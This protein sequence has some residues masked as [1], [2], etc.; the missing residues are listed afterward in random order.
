MAVPGKTGSQYKDSE[1][2]ILSDSRDDKYGVLATEMVAENPGGTALVRLKTDSDGA[3]VTSGAAAAGAATEATLALIKAKTDNIPAQGQALAAASMPVVLPAAQITTLTPPAAISGF[4]TETTL[5]SIKDTAGIKKITD[6]LPAGTN[7]L[8]KTGIDQ[9]TANANEVVTKTGSVTA[10]T[11]T[12]ETTKVIGTINVAAAQTIA[13]TNAGTF[14]TQAT[15]QTGANAIGKL[16]ANSGVDIGDVDVLS[17]TFPTPVSTATYSPTSFQNL[18]ANATLNVKASAG[19]VYSLYCNNENA[20]ERFIQLHNT[21]TTPAG[22]ATPL[23]TFRIPE[24]GD[25]LI[26][27]DFFTNAG[28]HFTTG[29]AFAFSTTKDTYTA[30]TATEQS[31]IVMYK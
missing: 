24:A 19:N 6:A 13:V 22:A 23:F 10:A 28:A 11:L 30:G 21:A 9:V 25:V 16:A 14:A 17:T 29:I 3:L 15:L 31:T 26:G 27:T 5:T 1:Q 8:G 20:A 7:L 18:G 4:A 12:A 2:V